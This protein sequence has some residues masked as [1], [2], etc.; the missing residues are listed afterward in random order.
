MP[1]TVEYHLAS[2]QTLSLAGAA[3]IQ[4][5]QPGRVVGIK[6]QSCGSGAATTG[7]YHVSV[8]HNQQSQLWID[9]NNPPRE[10]ILDSL[11]FATP[12]SAPFSAG[13]THIPLSVPLR[14]GDILSLNVKQTGTAATAAFHSANVCVMENGG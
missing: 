5:I 1:R 8:E 6:L 9:S 2:T 12:V 3:T 13:G 11:S 7:T 14:V 4:V 10:P